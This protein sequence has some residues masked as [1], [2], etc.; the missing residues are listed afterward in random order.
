MTEIGRHA[1][2][3]RRELQRDTFYSSLADAFGVPAATVAAICEAV[4]GGPDEALDVLLVPLLVAADATAG[5][6]T[7]MPAD[8]H[9]RLAYRRV[10]RFALLAGKL[11]LDPAEVAAV[12]TDQDLVGK[13]PENL[14][15]PPGVTRFDTLL[16][17]FDG[18]IYAVRLE[19]VTGPTPR[20]P[21]P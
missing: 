17:S 3:T 4:T 11:G 6:V 8:P 21:T 1:W 9:F 18:T 12:F 13:F 15:L 16:E 2:P 5:E 7:T 20:P 10:R 19:P 14:T